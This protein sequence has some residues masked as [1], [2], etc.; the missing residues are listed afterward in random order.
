MT[1]RVVVL[2]DYQGVAA[3]YADWSS[4]GGDVEVTFLREHIAEPDA[5]VAA[6]APYDVVCLM[7]E[8]TPI[9]ARTLDGLP[10]L[11]LLVTTG[12]ANASVDVEAATARGV[13]VCGTDLS[14]PETAEQAFL[15]I[16]AVVNGFAFE[17]EGVR[18]GAWQLG[19]GSRLAGTTLG[20]LGLGRLGGRVAAYA[21]AFDMPVLAWSQNLTQV[22]ADEVGVER[23]G[24]LDE[25]VT[26]S[27][28]VSIHLRLS[29]RTR[30]LVTAS[31]LALLGPDGYL[32]N[33]SRGP[34][35]VEQDLVDALRAGTIAGAALDTFDVEP[36][37]LDHPL[38]TERRALVT[39]HT[40][41][42]SRQAYA[43]MYA[44]TVEDIA[45]WLAGE[46]VRRIG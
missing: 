8:R 41:Y 32:V 3:S 46:P 20:L 42:V 28:V 13:L 2:D 12:M 45:A 14:G 27:D 6:L 4:L 43:G 38:R 17:A 34:I 31:Q 39:P 29:D 5:L 44:Q 36:L 18:A 22:R 15:M 21:R 9:D 19:V 35:V 33:T 30:G 26:R 25:L 37:P 40:G 16:G 23:V 11:R 1:T 7:R 10:R 24:S